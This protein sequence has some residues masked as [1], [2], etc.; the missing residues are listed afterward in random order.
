[1]TIEPRHPDHP[2]A[3]ALVARYFA[4]LSARLGGF[5]PQRD[6]RPASEFTP[7]AGLF[8][9]LYDDDGRALAC[10]GLKRL[11]L[12]TM[13]IKQMFVVPEA[14]GRGLGRKILATL[15]EAARAM[16]ADR[17]LLDTAAPLNE[18]QRL[19]EASGYRRIPPYNT[20]PYAAAWFE[21][22]L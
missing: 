11:A 10:G 18:A 8:L 14:R 1:M 15:E 17:V 2:D 12:G 4:E 19:Y 22:G 16:R 3:A 21:K 7:P 6:P 13:E 9:V 5:D 20:N